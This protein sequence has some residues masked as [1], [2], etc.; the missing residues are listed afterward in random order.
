MIPAFAL[1]NAGVGLGDGALSRALS[2]RVAWAVAI[3]L[4][5]GKCAGVSLFSLAAL[6]ARLGLLPRRVRTGHVVGAGAL[7]GVGFT[8]ALF[9]ATLAFEDVALQAEAKIGILAGSIVSALIG[10]I[11]LAVMKDPTT[12][13]A[14]LPE[15]DPVG[16]T[17]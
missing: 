11:V 8:V 3:G 13:D 5:I 7:G 4:V 1:A 9:I 15:E 12:S 17:S 6:R 16:I 2:S 14:R 10:T